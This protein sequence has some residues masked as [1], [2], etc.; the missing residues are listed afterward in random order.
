[1]LFPICNISWGGTFFSGM[2][3]P[4][5][6]LVVGP[7]WREQWLARLAQMPL[8]TETW[9]RHQRRDDYWKP[10]SVCEDY[11]RIKAA[12]YAVSGWQDSYSRAVLPLIANLS[13]P[14]KALIGQWA[15]G[16]PHMARPGPAIGFMQEAIRWWDHWLKGKDTGIMDEPMVRVW[17]GDWTKPAKFVAEW[18]GRWIAEDSWPSSRIA[19]RRLA[20]GAGGLGVESG[21]PR[22][23]SIRSPQTLGCRAGYQCSYGLGPD[24]SDDQRTDDGQS[25]C[26]DTPQLTERVEI[27][28][29]PVLE[30][31]IASDRPQTLVAARLCDVA[32]DGASLRIT[33][34]LLNLSHRDGSENP[35]PLIPGRRYKIHLKLC[36]VAHAF[37]AGHRIRV[38]LSTAYWP[39]VWPSP[40]PVTLTVFAGRGSALL[41]PV[42]AP[43]AIDRR[44]RPFAE[45][46]TAPEKHVGEEGVGERRNEIGRAHV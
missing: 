5:D 8:A 40:E 34:G 38:A 7:Q 3:R 13:V 14:K 4:P 2:T 31:D 39:I 9:L 11:A 37:P 46:V 36:G 29:E 22:T 19:A 30:L 17:M 28:G 43:Q 10:G 12:V 16:W 6:P 32:E 15:H 23:H 42:R 44:L 20:L 26:F 18:P 24:L 25:L 35:V 1:M 33:Y 21:P 45:P 41:L 27:L